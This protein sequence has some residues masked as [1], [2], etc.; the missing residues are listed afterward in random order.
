MSTAH[1][2]QLRIEVQDVMANWVMNLMNQN[3]VEPH[4]IED[5]LNKTLAMIREYVNMELLRAFIDEGQHDHEHQEGEPAV[6]E[7]PQTA[8]E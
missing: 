6:A 1:D 5:A 4:V 8:V 2:L 3:G 7:M